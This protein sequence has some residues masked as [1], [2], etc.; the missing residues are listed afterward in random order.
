MTL[1]SHRVIRMGQR[2]FTVLEY[3]ILIV[4]FIGAIY[5][6]QPYVQRGIQGQYRKAGESFGFLRQ[7][8]PGAS[9]DCVIDPA[10]DISYSQACFNNKVTALDC[11]KKDTKEMYDGCIESAKNACTL[12]CAEE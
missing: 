7:Y 10:L 1:N 5:A 8:N 9:L 6:F 4:V 12:G 11:T 2:A 3:V